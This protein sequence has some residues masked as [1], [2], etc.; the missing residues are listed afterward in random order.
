MKRLVVAMLALGPWWLFP[1]GLHAATLRSATTLDRPQVRVADLFDEPG[2]SGAQILGAGPA[3]GGRYVVE[4]AQAA[5]IARQFGVA[6]RPTTHTERVVIERPGRVMAR[7]ELIGTLRASLLA[8]G[9]PVDAELEI[10]GLTA[11]LVAMD[12]VP[13]IAVEQ[14]DYEAQ[15]GRFTGTLAVSTAFDP[16]QRLRLSGRLQAMV[17]IAVPTRRLAPGEVVVAGDLQMLRVPA[18]RI[19]AGDVL[20]APGQAIGQAMRRVALAG[21]PV[22]VADLGAPLIVQKGA[23]VMMSL[24]ASGLALSAVGQ[25]MTTGALG[26]RI[27]V[28]NPASGALLEA[29]VTGVDQVRIDPSS[30]PQMPSRSGSG[31]LV[32]R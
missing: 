9:A 26:D 5:A 32:L 23:R 22:P 27:N 10:P 6:W 17:D 24:N 1:A 18:G 15:T 20:R 2:A 21:Q 28:R 30:Q 13:V 31:Q 25:A 14:L 19:A 8:A 3:P 12:A 4:A 16:V 29:E 7:D 11:P